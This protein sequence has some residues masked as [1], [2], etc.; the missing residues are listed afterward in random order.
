MANKDLVAQ[1]GSGGGDGVIGGGGEGDGG[2]GDG[3]VNDGTRT[4]MQESRTPKDS[5]VAWWVRVDP[6]L[7]TT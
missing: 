7:T 1:S 3:A 5:S 2:G 4:W 6:T